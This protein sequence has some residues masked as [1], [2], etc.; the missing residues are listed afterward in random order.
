MVSTVPLQVLCVEGLQVRGRPLVEPEVFPVPGSH[1]IPVPLV[2]QLVEVER[3]ERGVVP[4][5]AIPKVVAVGDERLVLHPQKGRLHN[6]VLVGPGRVRPQRFF[7][8]PHLIK[9]AG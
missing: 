6:A 7:E 1:E 5:A 2:R 3:V 4:E 9:K 8:E